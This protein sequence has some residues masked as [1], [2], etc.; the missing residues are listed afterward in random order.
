MHAEP[1]S[2]DARLSPAA[3]AKTATT[4]AAAYDGIA[5]DYDRL[6]EGDAWMRRALHAHYRRTFRPGQRVLDVGCGTGIDAVALAGHGVRVLGLDA[7]P[8]M[9]GRARVRV[10]RAGLGASVRLCALDAADLG[11]LALGSTARWCG[12]ARGR[13]A[14]ACSAAPARGRAV[15]P[16]SDGPCRPGEPADG[17][18]SAFAA[19]NTV[20]DLRRLA[21]ALAGAVRPGGRLVLHMLNRWSLWEWLGLVR[22]ARWSAA[23]HLGR[24]AERAFFIGGR[25]VVHRLYAPAEAAAIFEHAGFRLRRAYGVGCLRPPHT[26][27][28]ISRPV[29]AGLEWLDLR[30]GGLAPLRAAGRFFVLDLERCARPG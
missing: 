8:A 6:V 3:P 27:R 26:V 22:H 23:W 4:A 13:T 29:V 10:A 20:P 30:L 24:A 9:V 28:R 17:A 1:G 21:V 11:C 19:L 7:S 18:I 16:P 25:P 14:R 15:R 5:A 12:D 2:K